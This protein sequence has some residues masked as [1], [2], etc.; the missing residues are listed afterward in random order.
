MGGDDFFSKR[1]DSVLSIPTARKRGGFFCKE[2]EGEGTEGVGDEGKE[3]E[4]V[5]EGSAEGEVV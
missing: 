1:A 2:R 3:R 5:S 4:V